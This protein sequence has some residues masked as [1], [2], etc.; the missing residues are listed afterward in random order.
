MPFNKEQISISEGDYLRGEHHAEFKY[1]YVDGQVY[2][3]VC[4]SANHN[5]LSLNVASQI[6]NH[7]KEYSSCNVFHSDFKVKAGTRFFYPDVVVRCDNEDDYYTEKPILIVEILSS[8]TAK[9]DRTFKLLTYKRIPSLV[10]YVMIEQGK[11][12]VEVYKL[13]NGVW[14]YTAYV[15]GDN[16]QFKSIGLTLSV[17][18]IYANVDNMELRDWVGKE[19]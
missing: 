7:L 11:C 16:V 15:L 5:H 8:T 12:F 1:E 10:E 13:A 14:D 17:E 18:T 6:R 3:M 2:A 19:K 4:A 9:Y